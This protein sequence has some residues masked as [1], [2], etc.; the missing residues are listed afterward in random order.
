MRGQ[1]SSTQLTNAVYLRITTVLEHTN[2][3]KGVRDAR[4]R[5]L[6]ERQWGYLVW[7]DL[8]GGREEL[9]EEI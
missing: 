4:Y 6:L 7:M 5:D 3:R 8:E 9:V 2:H 1:E